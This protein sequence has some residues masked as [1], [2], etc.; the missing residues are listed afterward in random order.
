MVLQGISYS[1]D[2]VLCIDATG[3]MSS[4]IDRVKANASKFYDDLSK[5]MAEKSKIIDALRVK[6]IVFR[7]YYAMDKEPM[8]ESP[9]YTLPAEKEAFQSFVNSIGAEGGG[10]EPENG[11][12]ALALAIKS[13]WAQSADKQRQIIVMWT[14]ASAHPLEKTGKPASYPKG[15]PPDFNGITDW[16]NGIDYF[17]GKS[18]RL[19]I[20][21]PDAYPWTDIA[22]SWKLSMQYASV[23]GE[24][25]KEQ[26]YSAILEAIANSV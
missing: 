3:S 26:E 21:A 25:L 2:M 7:D 6:V 4:I 12:E 9:F 18:K 23:A 24:G 11:L 16:W 14:D 8:V 15:L 13:D 10:D 20:Y 17:K 22:N 1:V 5:K 19:I